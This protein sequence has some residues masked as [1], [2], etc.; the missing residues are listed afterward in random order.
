VLLFVVGVPPAGKHLE[1]LTPLR[2]PLR[3]MRLLSLVLLVLLSF[4]VHTW[5]TPFSLRD[6]TSEGQRSLA[7]L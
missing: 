1:I 7:A 2:W 6:N 3:L 4:G 5:N